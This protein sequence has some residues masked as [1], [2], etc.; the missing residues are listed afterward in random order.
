MLRKGYLKSS[1]RYDKNS[2][3]YLVMLEDNNEINNEYKK[4]EFIIDIAIQDDFEF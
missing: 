2:K 4:Y 3:Y 1:I